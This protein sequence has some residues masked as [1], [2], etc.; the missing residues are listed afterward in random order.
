MVHRRG[1]SFLP[2][3][4]VAVETVLLAELLQCLAVG[5]QVAPLCG[6]IQLVCQCVG[7]LLLVHLLQ[8]LYPLIVV[9]FLKVRLELDTG[10]IGMGIEM[11]TPCLLAEGVQLSLRVLVEGSNHILEHFPSDCLGNLQL[12]VAPQGLEGENL[13]LLGVVKAVFPAELKK[14]SLHR[15]HGSPLG[16]GH[17]LEVKV[18]HQIPVD[19]CEPQGNVIVVK[20]MTFQVQVEKIVQH[21]LEEGILVGGGVHF[22]RGQGHVHNADD[23]AFGEGAEGDVALLQVPA[24]GAHGDSI[25]WKGL[26]FPDFPNKSVYKYRKNVIL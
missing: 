18:Q 11:D 25:A 21:R 4:L 12:Q 5:S 14:L 15:C 9:D 19:F 8:I 13:L 17:L 24:G 7:I 23:L 2:E 16:G 6:G 22:C 1:G 20:K 3:T 26:F 10:G